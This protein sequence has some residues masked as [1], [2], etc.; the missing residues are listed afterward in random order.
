MYL[1][2]ERVI[3][4]PGLQLSFADMKGNFI[5]AMMSQLGR[6]QMPLYSFL[7][8]LTAE[9]VCIAVSHMALINR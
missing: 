4:S 2:P 7:K 8:T 6:L 5:S 9:E 3:L 1:M